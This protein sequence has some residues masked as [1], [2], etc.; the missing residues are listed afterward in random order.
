MSFKNVQ[1]PTPVKMID[2][3]RYVE[4]TSRNNSLEIHNGHRFQHFQQLN[5][6]QVEENK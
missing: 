6:P 1:A 3:P 2:D 5:S 4:V